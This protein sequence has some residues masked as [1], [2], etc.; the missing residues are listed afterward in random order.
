MRIGRPQSE[1]LSVKLAS[2]ANARQC[3]AD[4]SEA[5]EYELLSACIAELQSRL[6]AG[7]VKDVRRKDNVPLQNRLVKLIGNKPLFDCKL[8]GI[9][10]R[11][12]WDTGSMISLIN[13]LWLRTMFPAVKVRPISDFL[14]G[15]EGVIKFTAANNTEV[16]MVGCVVLHFTMGGKTFPV[17][18]LVTEAELSQ[19]IVGFNVI[20]N[21]I[22]TEKPEDVVK[23]LSNSIQDVD[24]GKLKVMVNLVSQNVEADDFLGDLR[25]VKPCVIPAKGS[26]R[27]RCRVK[28]DVKGLDLLFLCSEP[29]VSDWDS[30]LIVS[31]S[32][33]ELSRGRTPH[34]NIEVRNVSA[35]EKY[36]HKN[37]LVGEICAINAVLPL[38]LFNP[39]PLESSDSAEVLNVEASDATGDAKWQPEANLDHLPEH[40]RK[41][42]RELLYE[43]CEVFAKTDS[44]IGDI[45]D[46]QMD[47]H[48]VDEVPVN[49]AYRHLPRK[50]YDDV[51]NYLND[52][53]VNGWIQKSSSAY[54]S[55]IVCVRK[56][57]N[58]MRLC[59]D[60]RKL[61]LKTI[62]DRQPIPRVQ[63]LL[64]GLY[65]NRYFSTLDM[66]KAYH[67]GYV[68][69]I[70]RKYTAFSTPW[71]LF[72]WLRIPFGLKNAP[73]AFQKYINTALE[74]LLDNVCLAYLDDIL[75][76]G[77]TFEEHKE[78]LRAVLQRLKS[79]GIKLRVSKCE[80]VKPEVRYLGRLVSAE[81]YRADPDDV[82]AL[83][84]FRDAPKTVGDVRS[85]LG[86]LGYYRG[87]VRDFAKKLKPVYD[88]LKVEKGGD[89]NVK[90]GPGRPGSKGYDKRKNV[91]WGPD[92]QSLVDD[93]INT[94]QSPKV[95][96]FPDFESPFI[97]NTDASGM[98]LGAV[99][100]Q[101]QGDD[102]LNRVISYASRTLSPAERNYHLHSGKLEFL[103]LK[104]AVTEKFA[105]YLGHGIK[106]TIYTD[107]NPLTYIMTSA[108]LNA[109]GMRWV[110]DLAGYNFEL[111]YRPGKS[112]GDADGL[113]RNPTSC[114][115]ESLERECTEK[116]ERSV[117][118]AILTRPVDAGCY[119]IAA[120]ILKFPA[121]PMFEDAPLS[122]ADLQKRQ[123]D[124]VDVG[125]VFQAVTL[126]TRPNRRDWK[127]MS[128]RSKLLFRQWQKLAIV[129]GILVR[130]TRENTQI[131]LP[132]SL[133][134]L[135]FVELH[136]KMGHLGLERVH[137]LARRRFFW[138]QM[139]A[140][141]DSFIKYRCPCIIG[142]QPNE[143]ERDPLV[144]IH[145]TYPF[146]IVSID[147]CKVDKGTGGFQFILVVTDHFTRFSQAY[148]TRSAKGRPAAEKIFNNFILQFGFPTRLHH[149]QGKEFN[150]DLF[151]DLHRL[152]GIRMSQTTPYHPEGNGQCER[153]NRTVINMLRSIPENE[154]RNWKDHLPKLMFAYNSTI[155]KST[156]FSPFY[157]LFG[158]E[159]RLP[160]D[161]A[162]PDVKLP[163]PGVA[164]QISVENPAPSS[165]FKSR[166]NFGEYVRQWDL[167][168][169]QAYQIANEKIGKSAGYNKNKHDQKAKAVDIVA[170]DRV[171]IRNVRPKGWYTTR[172]AKLASYWNPLVFEVVEKL[173]NGPVYVVR[174]WGTQK[175]PRVVHRN[176][177][178]KIN[179]LAP[180]PD[181]PSGPTP[182]QVRKNTVPQRVC[183]PPVAKLRD[184]GSTVNRN[185]CAVRSPVG[186]DSGTDSD[187]S[188]GTVVVV[189]RRPKRVS[190]RAGRPPFSLE[191][192]RD[193][194]VGSTLDETLLPQELLGDDND[195][196]VEV[197]SHSSVEEIIHSDVDDLHVLSEPDNE[198]DVPAEIGIDIEHDVLSAS[199][200]E[201]DVPAEMGIHIE[202]EHVSTSDEGDET[203]YEDL[204]ED[205]DENLTE[206][207]DE[208]FH[209]APADVE[210]D[211]EVDDAT[212]ADDEDDDD[213]VD[214]DASLEQYSDVEDRPRRT[215]TRERKP[216]RR[217]V[218]DELSR[219][220]WKAV[221][222]T[223]DS[224]RTKRSKRS[225]KR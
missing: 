225:A 129:D 120:D 93:V 152:T 48:L 141:I 5:S 165:E 171:V 117:L 62:A 105:D 178:K 137:D 36:I 13:L 224:K 200:N 210:V 188:A 164:D 128:K 49:Q 179:E 3:A 136:Q 184:G 55:P 127:T 204:G 94:L 169:N 168:M 29:C 109:T 209:S 52:L 24:T 71:A 154:R 15:G 8:D 87:Y 135:V 59:V 145:A 99:L 134:N 153:V 4:H 90:P 113:S 80:F 147:Y 41:E 133:H 172:K 23:F 196:V 106:S 96:A 149:D 92:L 63:D 16:A 75:I 180:V 205:M 19:P 83:E 76:Y 40:Q 221:E 166:G 206:D 84:K 43:E 156:G 110:S 130:E 186:E 195:S 27:V 28:G 220:V 185:L 207:A 34:V 9:D 202:D 60:Y 150:N 189:Q 12:L 51:K 163:A 101:K 31:E 199:G 115:I 183:A 68:R 174:E 108:K 138:P 38:Q 146:E 47:I 175:K 32:L 159:P 25:A 79:K 44:D 102:K 85:L 211:A 50:L 45:R 81:G 88:L 192:R 181:P 126:G 218:Y 20:E 1:G 122:R 89:G 214:L 162:F 201:H 124:D 197:L 193:A 56:K 10:T 112:N 203:V 143:K 148:P 33:G 222:G 107:N 18:F 100:Y 123:V 69:E 64:D 67:Q 72:E 17:P 11:V 66:A 82:K 58:T 125:P 2:V 116:C 104:W 14:E 77:R 217:F 118:S 161:D 182:K 30:D 74:G 53:I 187:S 46:F 131:I 208:S 212:E 78:N 54:A 144:P 114:D 111:K 119:A 42:I 194:S 22:R 35:S 167:R 139:A 70:C 173:K 151:S 158:R 6:D 142:K 213:D 97:L 216:P 95:M 91:V 198:H 103:A 21:L 219:P 121:P 155:H 157:L 26:A 61:N 57:D 132:E 176:L 140:D 37:M 65:G 86:F 190:A 98:G 170:G 73:A 191:G 7:K 223:G 160:I 215:G 177:L 39:S